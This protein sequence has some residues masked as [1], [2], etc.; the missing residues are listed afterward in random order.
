[1]ALSIFHRG[2]TGVG[3]LEAKDDFAT[4]GKASMVDE[5]LHLATSYRNT[6]DIN[7]CGP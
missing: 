1:M 7:H 3:K 2:D 4:N 5:G 6:M